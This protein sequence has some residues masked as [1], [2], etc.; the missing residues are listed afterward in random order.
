MPE[1]ML[2]TFF[3]DARDDGPF[4]PVNDVRTIIEFLDHL[5]YGRDLLVGNVRLEYDYQSFTPRM[6][7]VRKV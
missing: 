4:H 5:D 7:W 2:P 1:L 6:E 3:A